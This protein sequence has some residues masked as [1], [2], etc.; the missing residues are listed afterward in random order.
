MNRVMRR[1][2]MRRIMMIRRRGRMMRRRRG[3]MMRMNRRRRRSRKSRG[4]CF[5]DWT[6]VSILLISQLTQNIFLPSKNKQTV[7]I[8]Y[9]MTLHHKHL[10]ERVKNVILNVF[11]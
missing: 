2:R 4:V 11:I 1:R 8:R 5:P 10:E 7:D 6:P 3:R 9:F